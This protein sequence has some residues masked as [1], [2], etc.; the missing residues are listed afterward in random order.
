MIHCDAASVSK[1]PQ[2]DPMMTASRFRGPGPRT[3]PKRSHDSKMLPKWPYDPRRDP[4][5][6][7]MTLRWSQKHRAMPSRPRDTPIRPHDQILF[8]LYCK[9]APYDSD[10][11]PSIAPIL[12]N[13][14]AMRKQ[15]HAGQSFIGSGPRYVEANWSKDGRTLGARCKCSRCHLG[16]F[17]F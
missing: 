3:I 9:M 2:E 8:L 5:K 6:A 13:V 16:R 15:Y 10:V 7:P 1:R 4:N 14:V 12:P 17:R 11:A